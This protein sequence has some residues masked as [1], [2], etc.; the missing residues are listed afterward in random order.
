MKTA[1]NP[2]VPFNAV[3]A[4]LTGNV[5][6]DFWQAA[7]TSLS[8]EFLCRYDDVA[9]NKEGVRSRCMFALG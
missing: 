2:Q 5:D 6:R 9:K 4:K 7:L 3:L 8:D 1:E